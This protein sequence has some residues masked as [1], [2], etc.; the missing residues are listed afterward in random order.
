MAAPQ[1]QRSNLSTLIKQSQ[2]DFA[3]QLTGADTTL[4][5]SNLG[6]MAKVFAGLING[7]YGYVDWIWQQIFAYA[8]LWAFVFNIPQMQPTAAVGNAVFTGQING[9]DVPA[10]TAWNDSLGNLYA[11]TAN[12]TLEGNTV[13]VPSVAQFG[14]SAGNLAANAPISLAN[15]IEGINPDGQVDDNGFA[16]GTDLELVASWNARVQAWL[17]LP[18]QGGAPNDYV[19]WAKYGAPCAPTPVAAYPGVTRAWCVPLAGGAGTVTVYFTMDGRPNPIPTG[20]DVAAV[21]AILD[22]LAPGD[23]TVTAAAPAPSAV[24]YTITGVPVAMQAAVAAALASLHKNVIDAGQG[25]D[26]QSQVIPAVQAAA[27]TVGVN[28]TVPNADQPPIAGTLYTLG[29]ITW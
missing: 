11:T 25:I 26:L 4:R 8:P 28:V 19:S 10:G 16:G 12:G 9:T 21:Q 1:F 23:I 27:Q 29:N 24:N 20:G 14:G 2:G 5:R 13:T 7:V 15:S 17:Q 22:A 3:A 18:P 6:V